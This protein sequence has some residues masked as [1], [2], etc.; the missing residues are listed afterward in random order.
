MQLSKYVAECVCARFVVWFDHI[1]DIFFGRRAT[2]CGMRRAISMWTTR[3]PAP[4]WPSSPSAAEGAG[5]QREGVQPRGSIAPRKKSLRKLNKAGKCVSWKSNK[6]R[7]GSSKAIRLRH[8]EFCNNIL[9]CHYF[10]HNYTTFKPTFLC[11]SKGVETFKLPFF[12]SNFTH[13]LL[14]K[15]QIYNPTCL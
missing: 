2:C 14:L 10:W 12:E 8:S 3:A 5:P 7:Q 1:Y 9:I 11:A 4:L 15:N 6:T 13:S